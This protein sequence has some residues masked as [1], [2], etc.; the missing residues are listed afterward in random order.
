MRWWRRAGLWKALGV[1]LL[2]AVSG[3]SPA[4][5][6]QDSGRL[7]PRAFGEAA[8]RLAEVRER[9]AADL[10]RRA[11]YEGGGTVP[12]TLRSILSYCLDADPKARY[13]RARDLAE[14]LDRWLADLGKK[15]GETTWIADLPKDLRDPPKPKEAEP[16]EAEGGEGPLR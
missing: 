12:P 6:I 2:E 4:A 15:F 7:G 11:E 3:W 9:G 5:A 14:D 13:A 16:A 1:V 10:I 8:E